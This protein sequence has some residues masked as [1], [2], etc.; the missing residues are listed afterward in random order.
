MALKPSSTFTTDHGRGCTC[1]G[2]HDSDDGEGRW[3]TINGAAVHISSKGH[4]DKGPKE[5]VG[6]HE[7]EAHHEHHKAQ[8]KLHSSSAEGKGAKHADTPLHRKAASEHLSA[9]HQ[10]K[11]AHEYGKEGNI[12][13]AKN[14]LKRAE[15]HA[16]KAKEHTDELA[17]RNPEANKSDA[18]KAAPFKKPD[19]HHALHSDAEDDVKGSESHHAEHKRLTA[20][21]DKAGADWERH[22]INNKIS[23]NAKAAV[24]TKAEN[25]HKRAVSSSQEAHEI[26]SIE[27]HK[28][29]RDD[30]DKAMTAHEMAGHRVEGEVGGKIKELTKLRDKHHAVVKKDEIENPT[31]T[32]SR[33]S[34]HSTLQSALEH[35]SRHSYPT[36]VFKHQGKFFVPQNA[37]ESGRFKRAGYEV[38]A[39]YN[40]KAPAGKAGEKADAGGAAPKQQMSAGSAKEHADKHDHHTAEAKKAKAAGHH[41]IAS[42]HEQLADKHWQ[43]SKALAAGKQGSAGG[44]MADI[45]ELKKKLPAKP[46]ENK[47][48]V[49]RSGRTS[50][51]GSGGGTAGSHLAKIAKRAAE[52]AADQDPKHKK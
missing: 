24:K 47:P 35:Q 27:A 11:N 34:H 3:V 23:E 6:K 41:D 4:I 44:G 20:Q 43:V 13:A 5:L 51:H 30:I 25:M 1:H 12:N 32:A 16:A 21:Y 8:G 48:A 45:R 31:P 38:A 37:K 22:A 14:T 28:K 36:Q 40:G 10:F 26:D 46:G 33:V 42:L 15:Q 17:K 52:E 29:A 49:W 18:K 50:S 7:H 39:D 9:A 2:T 19:A